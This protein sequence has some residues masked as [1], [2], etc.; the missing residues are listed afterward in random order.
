VVVTTMALQRNAR[1]LR[2]A[3]YGRSVWEI[4]VPLAGTTLQP[5]IDSIAPSSVNPN[6]A[7]FTLAVTG[8]RFGSGT[9]LR[10]NGQARPTTLVDGSHLTAK[11]PASDIAVLGRASVSLLTPSLGGGVSNSAGFVIGP[12]PQSSSR[13]FVSAAN[14]LSANALAPRSI[15]SIYGQNLAPATAVADLAPPLPFTLG[16]TALTLLNGAQT[17]PVFFV[18]PTQINFQVPL[19][20][21]GAQTLTITQGVQSV[22]IPVQLVAYSPAL[23]TTN[24]QGT[25]Q[26]ATVIANTATLA[27]PV[28]TFPDSR[29]AKIGE[30]ISIYCTGLGDVTNRPG[31]GSPSPSN[32]LANTLAKP[33]VSI[34]GV[35]GVVAFS[36]LAPGYVGLYQVNLQVPATAP[37]GSAV[38]LILTIG[39]VVSNTVT[40]AVDPVL[41]QPEE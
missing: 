35:A 4:L 1:V 22:S 34:G 20:A 37:T 40:I 38:P 31:L 9:V 29:P 13:G 27:A 6:D 18:S 24:S 28:G 7:D 5:V 21:L 12:A 8:S 11:I 39:G 19:V 16:G 15:A 30:F 3:T 14:P 10:W 17:V 32:P 41:S 25:G 33:T 26:A 36:G 2:A 23:F